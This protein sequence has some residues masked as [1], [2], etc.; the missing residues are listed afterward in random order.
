MHPLVSDARSAELSAAAQELRDRVPQLVGMALAA[1]LLGAEL[2]QRLSAQLR[3]LNDAA[4][5]REHLGCDDEM[6]QRLCASLVA[7]SVEQARGV[8]A[9][10]AAR[11]EAW[12][13]EAHHVGGRAAALDD[14][15]GAGSQSA[16][17]GG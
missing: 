12:L 5:L 4:A 10:C 16:A 14:L 3:D 9:C 17:S 1:R 6:A 8:A 7:W 2:A 15:V 13:G 11:A